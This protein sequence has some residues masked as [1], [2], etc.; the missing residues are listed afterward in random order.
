M[1]GIIGG[2]GIQ[3]LLE[4]PKRIELETAY[5]KPSGPLFKGTVEGREVCLLPRHGM[6]H[7]YPPHKV[8]YRANLQALKDA[9]ATRIIAISAVGSLQERYKP[10]SISI[11]DQFIDHTKTRHY[12]YHDGPEVY[13]PGAADPF[14]PEMRDAFILGCKDLGIE[15][16]P[17][18]TYICVEGPRFSTR[19]ESR[20]FR[21]FAD[22][23]GMTMV[24]E[25]NLAI[26]QELCYCGLAMVTDYDV[27]AERPVNIDEVIRV[28]Q[29]NQDN[30]IRLLKTVIPAIPE[31]RS[32][33]CKDTMK[34][35]KV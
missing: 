12:T 1:I 19:A 8:P 29:E 18:G 30:V 20:M 7:Q 16:T 14:C 11:L 10:G 5:G 17:D 23:I 28:M 24:P 15:H 9:G 13:H 26:E 22:V 25:I 34:N 31:K 2:Y 32:C 21:G 35:A 6:E 27:W 33:P 4:E 3:S